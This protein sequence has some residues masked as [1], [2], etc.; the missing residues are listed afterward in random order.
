[1][2]LRLWGNCLLIITLAAFS[3]CALKAVDTTET[4]NRETLKSKV[5]IATQTSKFKTSVVSGIKDNLKDDVFYIKIVD[6]KWLPNETPN[7]FNAI[8][9]LNRC[10]AG[11]PDPRVES[12][13]DATP[14]K[15]KVILL[16]TGQLDSWEPD[17][18]EIDAMSSAS[19]MSETTPLARSIADKVMVI[20]RSQENMRSIK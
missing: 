5:L 16:T 2:Q 1:M 14:H 3:G 13:V 7:D 15:K 20:I 8:I 17:S 19:T 4:G 9:I 12:F 10:M 18:Q 6:V 11:R